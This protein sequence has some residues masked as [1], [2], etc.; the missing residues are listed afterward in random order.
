MWLSV[1]CVCV[2]VHMYFL[3]DPPRKD[4]LYYFSINIDAVAI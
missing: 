4:F 2:C 3:E 1:H